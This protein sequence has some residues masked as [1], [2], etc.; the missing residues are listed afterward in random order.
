MKG[1]MDFKSFRCSILRMR[2]QGVLLSVFIA[3]GT[4]TACAE[5]KEEDPL[6]AHP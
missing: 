1:R 5:E 2:I 6:A 3:V 4:G